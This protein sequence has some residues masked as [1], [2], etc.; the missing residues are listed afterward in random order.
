[1][2]TNFREVFSLP[3]IMNVVLPARIVIRFGQLLT[4]ALAGC[5]AWA[6]ARAGSRTWSLCLLVLGAC[7]LNAAYF[8]SYP[9]VFEYQYTQLTIIPISLLL[10]FRTSLGPRGLWWGLVA[11]L[12]VVASFLL[13]RIRWR[14]SREIRRVAVDSRQPTETPSTLSPLPG[15]P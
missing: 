9:L 14:L 3:T 6:A 8:L 12:A 7:L 11:G 15:E 10:G 13:V 2:A 5:L 1:M 4:L